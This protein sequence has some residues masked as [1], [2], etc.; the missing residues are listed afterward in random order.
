[1][2]YVLAAAIG[3]E[4]SSHFRSHSHTQL[5]SHTS[6]ASLVVRGAG[7]LVEQRNCQGGHAPALP[8]PH[9]DRQPYHQRPT[10]AVNLHHCPE[11]ASPKYSPYQSRAAQPNKH[12][13]TAAQLSLSKWPTKLPPLSWTSKP[14]PLS[15]VVGSCRTP[16]PFL[17][18]GRASCCEAIQSF[19]TG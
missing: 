7:Q 9:Y 15:P 1:M 13:E 17:E 18:D 5:L 6:D 3:T 11:T 2:K 4:W 8:L 19:C 12:L 10:A 14:I 16:L